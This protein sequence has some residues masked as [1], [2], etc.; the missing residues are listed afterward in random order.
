MN[1]ITASKPTLKF[2]RTALFALGSW[3]LCALLPATNAWA[4][5]NDF[6]TGS[7]DY[8]G[9]AVHLFVE[10]EQR[11]P[12]TIKLRR[13]LNREHRIDTR[14]YILLAV[15][16]DNL[17]ANDA[18]FARLSVGGHKGPEIQTADFQTRLLA[19]ADERRNWNLYLSRDAKIT[20]FT[21]ILAPRAYSNY[22]GNDHGYYDRG[23]LNNSTFYGWI[24]RDRHYQHPRGHRYYNQRDYNRQYDRYNGRAYD[25][26]FDR[27][28]NRT[29]D[30]HY[31]TH[32][33][34]RIRR[35]RQRQVPDQNTNQNQ[36]PARPGFGDRD[37]YEHE[38]TQRPKRDERLRG[39]HEHRGERRNNRERINTERRQSP[40]AATPRGA[41]PRAE[42]PRAR[43]QP[44]QQNRTQPRQ[45]PRQ[46]QRQQR[47]QAN[48]ARAQ[49]RPQL[50]KQ[51]STRAATP[52]RDEVR[53]R[54]QR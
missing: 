11:G 33:D 2:T 8:G 38:R 43:T 9:E 54:S 4:N 24:W 45:Q 26:R 15:V 6:Y 40:R 19:P 35:N 34:N 25:R 44:R 21:A 1:Q 18:G 29:R 20:G 39:N 50:S 48:Q 12:E 10:V 32:Q 46:Q 30:G 16:I 23:Y 14:D 3:I 36:R 17:D 7:Y 49:R 31:R 47:A 5:A 27:R 22:R 41:T 28:Y 53:Q 13:L 37:L 51:R 42:R 52:R